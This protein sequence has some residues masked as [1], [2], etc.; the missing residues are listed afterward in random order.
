MTSGHICG[1][2]SIII[3]NRSWGLLSAKCTKVSFNSQRVW[4][5][6]FSSL[7]HLSG[8]MCLFLNWGL[9]VDITTKEI[10]MDEL[11][12]WSLG[13]QILP[14][15]V[16]H[17]VQATG[18]FFSLATAAFPSS[19]SCVKAFVPPFS[20]SHLSTCYSGSRCVN[21]TRSTTV[22]QSRVILLYHQNEASFSPLRPSQPSNAHFICISLLHVVCE[23]Y[24]KASLGVDIP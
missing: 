19:L 5:I 8:S 23:F 10:K 6:F 11:P 14:G 22:I 17:I 2:P 21:Q 3:F 15:E 4:I 20:N 9:C 24:L 13:H 12:S 1:I 7:S 16:R 18:C